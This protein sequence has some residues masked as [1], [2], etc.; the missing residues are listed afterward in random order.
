MF[1]RNG[2]IGTP[3]ALLA[4]WSLASKQGI[5]CLTHVVIDKDFVP[6]TDLD[7]NVKRRW[8]LTLENGLLCASATSFL[9]S[10]GDTL[11][12]THQVGECGIGH[13][14][15]Q[16][17]SVSRADKLNTAFGNRSRSLGLEFSANL[18]DDN[19]LGHVVLH[20]LDHDRMLFAWALHLHTASTT[21]A[22]VSNIPVTG[23]F[24]GGINNN[25]TLLHLVGQHTSS[26]A[27]HG[28]LTDARFAKDKH[29]LARRHQVLDQGDR[30]GDG[31]TKT[32]RQAHNLARAAA[33][34]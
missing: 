34:S 22:R 13:K 9:V 30:T 28:C 1:N 3:C 2:T 8:L 6:A 14:V 15:F 23:Y 24:I 18:V 26:L 29:A 31:S 25:H 4:L 20:C 17:L 16:Q 10:K 11:N 5:D 32:A 33:D 19:D 21:D 12:T 27:E 7:K